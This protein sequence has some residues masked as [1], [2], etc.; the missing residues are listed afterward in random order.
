MPTTY[1]KNFTS[2]HEYSTVEVGGNYS[3]NYSFHNQGNSMISMSMN[4]NQEVTNLQE[5]TWNN[6][7]NGQFNENNYYRKDNL[8]TGI[9]SPSTY[10]SNSQQQYHNTSTSTSCSSIIST[11]SD[12]PD[13]TNIDVINNCISFLPN[14]TSTLNTINRNFD[15]S[16]G[17]IQNIP[18]NHHYISYDIEVPGKTI[19][20]G[21]I[22]SDEE[23]NKI[24]TSYK[25]PP[26][27]YTKV[28]FPP[29]AQNPKCRR[30][31]KNSSTNRNEELSKKRTFLCNVKGC[32]KSYTKSS[33]LKAHQR[34]HTGEKPYICEWPQCTWTFARSDEL[35]RHYRMHTGAKPFKC[36]LCSSCFA[37]SDHL[38]SHAKKHLNKNVDIN[39]L[40]NY[41]TKDNKC[42]SSGGSLYNEG[43]EEN[44]FTINHNIGNNLFNFNT[45]LDYTSSFPTPLYNI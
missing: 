8:Y 39:D 7:G 16:T 15:Q 11:P 25:L 24:N 22:N 29:S 3:Q 1:L 19:T 31:G 38:Q 44:Y 4:S 2:S 14:S 37:R 45:S 18:K 21:C 35:T 41:V 42:L 30:N 40:K 12:S 23:N 5:Y 13:V 9:L 26:H 27:I 20:T 32:N 36:Q 33:H 17:Y 28:Y 10:L 43:K 34:I 6:I